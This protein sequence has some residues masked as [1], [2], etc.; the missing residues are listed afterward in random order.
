MGVAMLNTDGVYVREKRTLELPTIVSRIRGS[1]SS[2]ADLDNKNRSVYSEAE[3]RFIM[4][5]VFRTIQER[6]SCSF[7]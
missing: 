7:Q 3:A 6:S 2:P 1:Q 4:W 5:H